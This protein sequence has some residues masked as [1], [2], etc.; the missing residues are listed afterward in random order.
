LPLL[1]RYI[2]A[3]GRLSKQNS[4]KKGSLY[5]DLAIQIDTAKLASEVFKDE[6]KT[7]VDQ[8][9]DILR[10]SGKPGQYTSKEYYGRFYELLRI[11][12]TLK[13]KLHQ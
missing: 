6:L 1:S 10:K 2:W 13:Q 3:L 4:F 9:V 11:V 8:A 12:T 7:S 5:E